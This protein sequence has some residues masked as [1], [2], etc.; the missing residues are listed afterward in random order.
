MNHFRLR[1]KISLIV[2]VMVLCVLAVAVTGY[3]GLGSINQRVNR[4]VEITSKEATLG[5][6]IRSNLQWTRRLENRAVISTSDNQ[7]KEF[8][9][10]SRQ[11]GTLVDDGYRALSELIDPSP[12]SPDRQ[13][14]DQF[15]H[16]WKDY[17]K[18][19][20][21]TLVLAVENSNY[22]AH[23]LATGKFAERVAAVNQAAGTWLARL[24][25]EAPESP[26]DN[27]AKRAESWAKRSRALNKLQ[28]IAFD[29]QRQLN[30]QIY[31]TTDDN[32][33]QVDERVASLQKEAES[34]L[35]EFASS[36]NAGDLQTLE[37]LR[38]SFSDLNRIAAQLQKLLRVNS[39]SRAQKMLESSNKLIDEGM[40][41]LSGLA[42]ILKT[43]LIA[44]ME[45]IYDTS[46]YAQWMMIFV[47]LAG[48]AISLV[49][50]VLLT[51][52][53]TIHMAR[54]VEF[55][56]ALAKGDLSKRLNLAQR[57]EVGQLAQAMD[58]IAASFGRIVGEIRE[59]SQGIGG[60]ASELSSVSHQLLAQSEEMSKQAGHVAG[61]AEQM[62]ANI[63]TMA[64]AAE[65]M[66]MNVNSISSASEQISVNVGAI[67]GA[68]GT[69]A[70]NV[71]AVTES[72]K[73][74]SSVFDAV[75]RDAAEESRIA[76][77]AVKMAD[78]ANN[79]MK[80]LDRSSSEISKVTETIKMIALQTNLLALNAT[81]EA[82][83][84]GE[85]GK[86][87]AVVANEIK[88]LAHQSAQ[89]AENIARKIEEVQT[90]TRDAVQVIQQVAEIIHALNAASARISAAIEE[91]NCSAQTCAGNLVEANKGVDNIALSIAEVA[92][93]ASDMSRNA[94][95][96]AKGANDVSNNAGEA[97]KAVSDISSNIHG[98]SQATRD[99]TAS[100]QQVN[101][102][103]ERLAAIADRLQQIVLQFK[104]KD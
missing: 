5:S 29:L 92:K 19:Q 80:G 67:S 50:S 65:E 36:S 15:N 57:D 100:A 88:E 40:Y 10:Q 85:A 6:D 44:D 34:L 49:L 79:T 71:T 104:I 35:G 32:M 96:A 30:L 59:V 17:R 54:G 16:I 61:G 20:D 8:A 24:A 81:I 93:G 86:G 77:K 9:E 42:D 90:G 13:F 46:S 74:S 64:A 7:C 26:G 76:E 103:A 97:A 63:T 91:Q 89:A 83:S 14:L 98:V 12:L 60:S 101:A 73:E 22:K 23:V 70:Q 55:S 28:L 75:S 48:I 27:D 43:R 45:N 33:D 18:N 62:A 94:G 39:N 102:A 21:Q 31:D 41:A 68:A 38:T 82:T 4:M 25:K 52:S 37:V 66:S 72:I 56:D 11:R 99:N 2:G 69:T 87:F 58:H 1:T 51:R 53:V 3:R 84:A 78:S 95:E 47:P